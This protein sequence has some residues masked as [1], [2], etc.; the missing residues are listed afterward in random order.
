MER[1]NVMRG[2]IGA[3]LVLLAS[4]ACSATEP[5]PD[6]LPAAYS[7]IAINGESLQA[8]LASVVG[9]RRAQC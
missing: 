7:L 3:A 9:G 4:T 5:A 1:E 8:S 2:V 6:Y